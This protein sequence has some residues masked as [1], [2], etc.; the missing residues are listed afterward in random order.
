MKDV[1]IVAMS[2]LSE[3]RLKFT[4]EKY[5]IKQRFTDFKRML[6]KVDLDT[7]Y[8]VV[9]PEYMDPIVRYCLEQGKN[10]FNEKPAGIA[11]EQTARWAELAEKKKCKTIV[12]C[13]RRFHPLAVEARKTLEERGPILYSMA[14]FHKSGDLIPPRRQWE[15]E[16]ERERERSEA[17]RR[18]LPVS[19]QTPAG[20]P[21]RPVP[22]RMTNQLLYDVVHVIDFLI[23]IGGDV[24]K[25][26]SLSGQN[27]ADKDYFDPLHINYWTATLEF[28]NGGIGIL[29]SCRH[30]GGRSLHFEMHGKG[31]S[32]YGQIHGI[33]GLD[34]CLIQ[35]DDE[36]YNKARIVKNEEL[37]GPN[38]PHTHIDGTFQLDRH[39]MDCIKE[40]KEPSINFREALKSME[41][42]KEIFVGGRLPSVLD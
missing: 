28:K 30:A 1:E 35:K 3:E 10:V 11:A 39:F 26:H 12:C 34:S 42:I 36:P 6:E 15:M 29:N 16:L 23:W 40:D 7:V 18:E 13:Q 32:A 33:P 19:S 5:G 24:R 4:G 2:D 31:V 17:S 8:V 20:L 37:I 38:A 25:V 21:P 14:A 22:M 9:Q 41:V 27:Y